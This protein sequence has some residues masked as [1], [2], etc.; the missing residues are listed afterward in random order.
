[1][2]NYKEAIN[3]AYLSG[4][5]TEQDVKNINSKLSNKEELTDLDYEIVLTRLYLFGKISEEKI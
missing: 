5:L 1:M 3:K 2:K 4:K